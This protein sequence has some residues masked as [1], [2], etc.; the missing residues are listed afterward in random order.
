[1]TTTT[2]THATLRRLPFQDP[3][4]DMFFIIAGQE[5][6]AEDHVDVHLPMGPTTNPWWDLPLPRCPDCGGVI[7][8]YEAGY[9][10]GAR[11]CVGEPIGHGE[12]GP[13]YQGDGGCGSM[14]LVD[15]HPVQ[16]GGAP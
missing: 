4:G 11:K 14:F 13:R 16:E 15:T 5:I 3:M 7:I 6:P 9:V 2:N 8:W 12:H 1:M 10:P